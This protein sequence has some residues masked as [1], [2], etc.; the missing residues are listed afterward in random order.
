MEL[1]L[2]TEEETESCADEKLF[3]E[4]FEFLVYFSFYECRLIKRPRKKYSEEKKENILNSLE[5]L[6]T[7][8]PKST[9]NR[10][11]L[12]RWRREKRL[13]IQK[14]KPGRLYYYYY[15]FFFFTY[16]ICL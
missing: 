13:G 1:E 2:E 5:G 8:K 15:F 12:E 4:R 7:Y 9:I 11:T 3:F 6:S 10:K 16:F 14:R